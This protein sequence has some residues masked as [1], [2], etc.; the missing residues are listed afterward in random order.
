M[1]LTDTCTK[2]NKS[3][4]YD[5]KVFREVIKT[6][7]IDQSLDSLITLLNE[8]K[9]EFD[10][11]GYYDFHIEQE[12]S[13]SYY[14]SVEVSNTIRASR[15]E[16]DEEYAKRIDTYQK[17]AKSAELMRKAAKIKKEQD[18]RALYEALKVKYGDI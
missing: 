10:A 9:T 13:Y 11:K 15:T 3:T 18:D 17:Q 1:Q 7:T 4:V 8:I 2:M 12:T 6:I 16:T 5:K 14:D